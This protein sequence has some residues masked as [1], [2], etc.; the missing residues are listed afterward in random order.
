MGIA[1]AHAVTGFV[2]A[3]ADAGAGATSGHASHGSGTRRFT[4]PRDRANVWTR[5]EQPMTPTLA[6]ARAADQQN[7]ARDDDRKV[8]MFEDLTH[9][10]VADYELHGYRSITCLKP[11]IAHLRSFFGTYH[12]REITNDA[13]RQYQTFRRSQGASAASVNRDTTGLNRMFKIA[14][15]RGAI[16]TMPVFPRRLRENPPRQGFFEHTEFV[17]VRAQLPPAFR[18]VLEFAYY[19]G[20]RRNEILYLTWS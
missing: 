9:A 14:V 7:A 20:W 13:I 1:Q 10:Y 12:V 3:R 18:D 19:S 6:L 4:T 16:E 15:E 11:R 17:K 5:P 2:D 8:K